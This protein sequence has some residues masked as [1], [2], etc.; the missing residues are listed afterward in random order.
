MSS[1]R[2]RQLL[3]LQQRLGHRFSD[4]SL[5]NL[6]LTHRSAG[7]RNNERLEFLGDSIVNHVVAEVLYEKFPDAHEG[8][9]SR[10]RAALVKGD[11]LA[12]LARE[13]SLG[14]HL[15]LGG[16]ERK[17]GGRRRGSILADAL[18][19]V[20]GAIFIDAGLVE[21]RRCVLAWYG[22]QLDELSVAAVAKDPKTRL[23]EF[24]QG[25]G[26]PLPEYALLGVEGEDHNQRFQVACRISKPQMVAEGAGKSRRKAEQAAAEAALQRL[27][28][29]GK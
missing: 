21:S 5:L 15:L 17:S 20:A 6:A 29:H 9:L 27:E 12:Q 18:E 1:D 8:D 28:S 7:S 16:G 3:E 25:R 22:D 26:I 4:E 10:L 19:A 13:L 14:E 2:A 23:Q 24:L 11:T